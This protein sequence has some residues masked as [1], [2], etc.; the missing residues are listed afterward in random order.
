ME[1]IKKKAGQDPLAGRIPALCRQFAH[2]V[3]ESGFD[4]IFMTDGVLV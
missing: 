3:A 4:G 2:L 1:Y